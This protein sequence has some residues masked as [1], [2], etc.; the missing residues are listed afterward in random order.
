VAAELSAW[1]AAGW[2][3]L[4]GAGGS[5]EKRV[6]GVYLTVTNVT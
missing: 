6:L 2:D 1:S 5:G 3:R 4:P